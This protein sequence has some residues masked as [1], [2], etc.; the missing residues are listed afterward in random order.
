MAL[1]LC[2]FRVHGSDE[3]FHHHTF[4]D[5]CLSRCRLRFIV[6]AD[7]YIQR[8]VVLVVTGAIHHE[9]VCRLIEIGS[10]V[11]SRTLSGSKLFQ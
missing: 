6:G 11:G 2:Q 4:L 7:G 3:C 10:Q 8:S 9:M 5:L 1:V